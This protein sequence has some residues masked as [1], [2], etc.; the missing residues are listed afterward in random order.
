M[1]GTWGRGDVGTCPCQYGGG[2][3]P[4]PRLLAP[5]CAPCCRGEL[6]WGEGDA[7]PQVVGASLC[8]VLR[9][10]GGVSSPQ[11]VGA[12]VATVG[13]ARPPHP[14]LLVVPAWGGGGARFVGRRFSS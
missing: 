14:R 3:A 8:P 10:G 2:G 11:D 5:P 4:H 12:P 7:S 13:C 6:R 9:G 1:Q